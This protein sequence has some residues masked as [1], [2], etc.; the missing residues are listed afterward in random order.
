MSLLTERKFFTYLHKY[1]LTSSL[2][3]HVCMC[4]YVHIFTRTYMCITF[5]YMCTVFLHSDIVL[6]LKYTLSSTCFC[7]CIIKS[8]MESYQASLTALPIS[9]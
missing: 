6:S 1:I 8:V 7:L 2:Y 9:Q 4:M 5:V 3:V